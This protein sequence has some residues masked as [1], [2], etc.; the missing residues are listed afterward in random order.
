MIDPRICVEGGEGELP[1]FLLNEFSFYDKEGHMVALDAN[2]IESGKEIKFS[3]IVKSEFIED[4]GLAILDAG[5]IKEW[6]ITG[7][8]PDEEMKV[9]TCYYIQGVS[10]SIVFLPRI[11]F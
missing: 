10:V 5:P 1:D 8:K 11:T 3:G 9:S 6:W 2:L 7:F 4:A